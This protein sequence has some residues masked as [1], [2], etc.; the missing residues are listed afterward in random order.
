VRKAY[1]EPLSVQKQLF[2]Q[3]V[4]DSWIRRKT[5]GGFQDYWSEWYYDMT[6]DVC[7]KLPSRF[8]CR[9]MGHKAFKFNCLKSNAPHRC[10]LITVTRPDGITM[11]AT[12]VGNEL[13][14]GED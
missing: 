4:A 9:V 12:V 2:G 14:I 13:I 1:F 6:P 5:P 8:G 3:V 10:F 11:G 7:A